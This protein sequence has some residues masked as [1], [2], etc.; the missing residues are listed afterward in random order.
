MLDLQ[1]CRGRCGLKSI[2]SATAILAATE[3]PWQPKGAEEEKLAAGLVAQAL[4]QQGGFPKPQFDAVVMNNDCMK[5]I[6]V[7]GPLAGC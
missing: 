2:A 7:Y 6:G 4:T 5:V 1:P 3:R